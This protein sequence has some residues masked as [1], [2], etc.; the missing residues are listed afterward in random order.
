MAYI[1]FIPGKV[2]G[3]LLFHIEGAGRCFLGDC[4]GQSFDA[5][6]LLEHLGTRHDIRKA[7]HIARKRRKER[8]FASVLSIYKYGAILVVSLSVG[9]CLWYLYPHLSQPDM[10][11]FLNLKPEEAFQSQDVEIRFV[12]GVIADGTSIVFMRQSE[13][14][15]L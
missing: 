6:E 5:E 12:K 13:S 10:N 3:Y 4:I 2:K 7:Y 15:G 8:V 11:T 1:L 14:N 9:S